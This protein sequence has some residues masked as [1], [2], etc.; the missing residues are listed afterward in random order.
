MS[1][2]TWCLRSGKYKYV[3]YTARFLSFNMVLRMHSIVSILGDFPIC[4]YFK[5]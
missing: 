3:D 4:E 1:P 5:S 2:L